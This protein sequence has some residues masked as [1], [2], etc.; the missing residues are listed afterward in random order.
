MTTVTGVL[1]TVVPV[2]FTLFYALLGATFSYPGI[3][4]E[5]ASEVLERFA[6]GGTRLVLIWWAFTMSAVAF[7]P[8]ALGVAAVIEGPLASVSAA[9]GVLAALVQALGLVRW[10]FL[11]P[12]LARERHRAPETVDLVFDVANRYL[13][14]AVGEHL[15]YLLTASWTIVVSVAVIPIAPLAFVIAGAVIG[16]S[17][18]FGALEFVGPNERSGWHLAGTVVAIGYTAWAVWL[19]VG[20]V[21]LL[22][23]R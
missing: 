9:L 2:L 14:V 4:R 18:L 8:V 13:G 22:L 11:V 20:G 6:A 5:P 7:V 21:L 15:G 12:Y 1:L 16:A 10:P 23:G 17:L 19:V 3:L